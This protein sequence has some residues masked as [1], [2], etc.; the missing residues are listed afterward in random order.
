MGKQPVGVG[1]VFP[2]G[3][4]V[5]IDTV[6]GIEN[7]LGDLDKFEL[8]RRK[9]LE[10]GQ[11]TG[12][13]NRLNGFVV[14]R[15]FW[16]DSMGNFYKM[17][18]QSASALDAMGAPFVYSECDPAYASILISGSSAK[19][20]TSG[21]KCLRCENGWTIN[22]CWDVVGS[23]HGELYHRDCDKYRIL[24]THQEEFVNIMRDAEFPFSM[25]AATRNEYC[26]CPKCG[27]WFLFQTPLGVL[28]MG[29]RKRVI[30]IDWSKAKNTFQKTELFTDDVTKGSTFIHA[31]GRDKAV[32]YL[33]IL[34]G[35]LR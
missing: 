16:T 11:K 23:R 34:K 18:E 1:S 8:L 14:L 33:K 29:W 22:D 27:P 13:D 3:I 9:R 15:R 12:P 2:E 30:N 26:R 4:A 7:M 17:D 25:M 35:A 24:E 19:I 5:D 21:D 28:K 6:E 31:W 20:P 32:E 10:V